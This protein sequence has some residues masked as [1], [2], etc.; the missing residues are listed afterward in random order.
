MYLAR[1]MAG[2]TMLPMP[3]DG[4]PVVGVLAGDGDGVAAL[5]RVQDVIGDHASC[6]ARLS[7][8]G[9]TSC[10]FV[11]AVVD[12]HAGVGPDFAGMWQDLAQAHVPRAVLVTNSVGGRADFAEMGAILER[13]TG[14]D[15]VARFLPL[16]ADDGDTVAGAYDVLDGDITDLHGERHPGDPEHRELTQDARELLI[17]V[18]AHAVLGDEQLEGYLNGSPV[19]LPALRN[20]YAPACAAGDSVVA[21]VPAEPVLAR[22]AILPIISAIPPR[23]L[24]MVTSHGTTTDIDAAGVC[25]GVGIDAGVARLWNCAS[26]CTCEIVALD[27]TIVAIADVAGRVLRHASVTPGAT[28]RPVGSD[29]VVR[30]PGF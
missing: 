16:A 1:S 4:S 12:G 7:S 23:Q 27:G 25:A 11:L 9:L 15:F 5:L 20:G 13:V 2:V 19:S 28:I 29:L 30:P 3:A 10:D 26:P 21:V 24:P 22:L 8:E 14:D 6:I 18:L 17:D